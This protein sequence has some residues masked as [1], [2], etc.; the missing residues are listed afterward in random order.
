VIKYVLDTNLYVRAYRNLDHA[1]A[2]KRFSSTNA[3]GLYLSSVV[4]HELMFGAASPQKAEELMKE[5]LR[6]FRRT[7]R[8]V[9]PSHDAWLRAG[10]LLAQF[11]WEEGLERGTVPRSLV[12]DVL[13]AASC[14]EHG[15][16]LVTENARDFRRIRK[17][18]KFE[19]V[20]PWPA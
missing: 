13:L 17:R 6:P 10:N 4:L 7:H 14:R 2:L 15:L 12:N 18:M 19:F 16:T 3:R 8:T 9:T 5:I 11:A 1:E 20:A